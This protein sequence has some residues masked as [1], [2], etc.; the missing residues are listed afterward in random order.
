MTKIGDLRHRI[1]IETLSLT[2]NDSGGQEESWS[3]FATVWAQITPVK[4][5]EAMQQARIEMTVTHKI[6]IRE[7]PGVTS[8]MRVAFG[9]RI[10]EIK[11]ILLDE[12]IPRGFQT[13]MA[14]ERTGT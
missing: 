8:T 6:V 12:E 13:L 10:F 4:A 1:T 5:W 2:P 9:D 11:S 3:T 14:N 7:L